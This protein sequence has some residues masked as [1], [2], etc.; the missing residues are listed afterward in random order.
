VVAPARSFRLDQ[1]YARSGKARARSETGHSHALRF[2]QQWSVNER[3][4]RHHGE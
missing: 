1:A 4:L 3:A 2:L